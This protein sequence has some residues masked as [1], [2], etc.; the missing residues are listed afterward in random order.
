MVVVVCLFVCFFFGGDAA[1]LLVFF[2]CRGGGGK[3]LPFLGV[4]L[5]KSAVNPRFFPY[6]A[7]FGGPEKLFFGMDAKVY[8]PKQRSQL[9]KGMKFT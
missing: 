4:C 9:N 5:E 3:K 6:Q 1:F 2:F 7:A 8:T